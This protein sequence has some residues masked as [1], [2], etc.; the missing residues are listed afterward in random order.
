MVRLGAPLILVGEKRVRVSE[1]RVGQLTARR[2]RHVLFKRSTSSFD[3]SV[4]SPT[5]IDAIGSLGES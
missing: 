5:Y 2:R 4:E 3:L 1:D